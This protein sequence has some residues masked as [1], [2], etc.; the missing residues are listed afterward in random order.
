MENIHTAKAEYKVS[1][2]GDDGASRVRCASH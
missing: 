2:R 1:Y